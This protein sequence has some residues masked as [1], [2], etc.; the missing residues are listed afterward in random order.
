MFLHHLRLRRSV[1]RLPVWLVSLVSSLARLAAGSPESSPLVK[2][3][4]NITFHLG[5]FSFTS[6]LLASKA[7]CSHVQHVPAQQRL[8]NGGTAQAF[9]A[10]EPHPVFRCNLRLKDPELENLGVRSRR[11]SERHNWA[12]RPFATVERC[13]EQDDP[14]R[15]KWPSS[16]NAPTCV[17]WAL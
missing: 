14:L 11:R 5:F 13:S 12:L 3:E 8:R 9:H 16:I 4:F 1:M 6:H 2:Y 17:N 15:C 10:T 7:S